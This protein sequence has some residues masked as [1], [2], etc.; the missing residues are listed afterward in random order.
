MS[1]T[2]NLSAFF[3]DDGTPATGLSPTI[4]V[5]RIDTGALVVTDAAM[6]EVGDGWYN[7]DF[8]SL[9][10]A[11]IADYAIRADGGAGIGIEDRYVFGTLDATGFKVDQV[12]DGSI[13]ADLLAIAGGSTT[14]VRT[15]ATQADGFY[16]ELQ[17]VVLNAAGVVSRRI[18]GYLNTNGAFTVDPALPFTPALNDRILV[19]ARTASA[20]LDAAV[21]AAIEKIRK[22]TSNRVLVNA[23]DTLVTVFEDDG[24]TPAFSFTISADRRDRTPV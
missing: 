3:S 21:V 24:S 11:A 8:T 16:D 23:T 20:A 15:G 22:V 19:L 9:F 5:R 7:F 10:D 18:T 1:E 13:A 12:R 2:I 6:T 17:L 14:E 4:R